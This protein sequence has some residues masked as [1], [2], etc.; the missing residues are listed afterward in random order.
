MLVEGWPAFPAKA[1]SIDTE[2]WAEGVYQI[3]FISHSGVDT[4]RL[5]KVN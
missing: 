2:Q 5:V 3:V 1:V 4:F